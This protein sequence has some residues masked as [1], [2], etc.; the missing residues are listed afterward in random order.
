MNRQDL[1]SALDTVHQEL[2]RA[3]QLDP[4]EVDKLKEAIDEIQAVIDNKTHPPASLGD[5]LRET[6]I[7][8]EAS[9]PILTMNLGRIADILQRMGF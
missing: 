9:H 5:R 7:E 3:D 2:A 6:A 8:F 4:A 1:E